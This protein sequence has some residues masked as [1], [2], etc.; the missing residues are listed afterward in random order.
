MR[1]VIIGAGPA[2][3]V[4]AETLR[5]QDSGGEIFL[6]GDEPEPAYSRMAIPYLLA[7]RIEESGTYLRHDP[8]HFQ[9]LDIRRLHE[10]VKRVDT[11]SNRVILEQSGAVEY[12]RLLLASGSRAVSPPIE[13][14]DQ[15]GI[16]HCWTLEDARNIAEHAVAGARVVLMGAGFIGCIIME[17]LV[18]RGVELT[19]VEMGDRMVP[20]MMDQVAGNLIKQWCIGKGV[21]VRTSTRVLSVEKDSAEGT[22]FLLQCEGAADPLQ[23]DLIVV[24]TG[25][26]PAIEYL[27]GSGIETST[28]VLVDAQLQT[29]VAGVYA[30]GDLCEGFDWSTG[31]RAVNAIQ[32][33]AVETGR[34]AALNMSGTETPY[35][36]GLGMNVLDTLGLVSTSYG[37]WMGVEDGSSA[38]LLD[39]EGFRYINLQFQ[40]DHLVG[41]IT[42]GMTERVGVLR[43][44]IQSKVRLGLWKQRLLD[45]P[46]RIMEAYLGSTQLNRAL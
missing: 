13:G 38:S 14:L 12:D 17:S 23:A 30:A 33:A 27:E 6:I 10:R 36:G 16:H 26:V 1:Y 34:V 15:T 28:G 41:A 4:A 24:A 37:L 9:G 8:N 5:G 20:R 39:Q 31:E 19:V 29:S 7:G 3:V 45:D 21:D 42:L 40:D 25:V 11:G 43:G 22:K 18:R 46:T 2:G 32:P 35:K 44:L